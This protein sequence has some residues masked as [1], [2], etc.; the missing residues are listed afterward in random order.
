MWYTKVV[1]CGAPKQSSRVK[2]EAL[3]PIIEGIV[4]LDQNRLHLTKSYILG[5]AHGNGEL[6]TCL[7]HVLVFMCRPTAC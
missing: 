2:F 5:T 4:I 3:F 7:I 6:A 1:S